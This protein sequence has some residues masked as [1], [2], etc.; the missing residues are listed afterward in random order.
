M[1]MAKDIA[2]SDLVSISPET[3][4]EKA[5]DCLMAHRISGLPI[6]GHDAQILG[7]ITEFALLAVA[8]E[9]DIASEPVSHHMTK[10]VISVETDAPITKIADLFVRHRIRRVFVVQDGKLVG[11]I[12]RRDLLG[13]I[14][15]SR[16]AL[17]RART[18]SP[19]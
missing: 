18:P 1:L 13:A 7:V 11:L 16:K 2:V 12:S 10:D 15:N 14:M 6:V 5:I 8:Y 3:T 19:T 9:P 17:P 4:V